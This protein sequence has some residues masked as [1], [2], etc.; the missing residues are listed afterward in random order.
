[1]PALVTPSALLVCKKDHC[2][3][4]ETFFHSFLYLNLLVFNN[5]ANIFAIFYGFIEL[6]KASLDIPSYK[7]I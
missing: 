2:F 1:M 6:R 7:V 3:Y 5:C 4:F